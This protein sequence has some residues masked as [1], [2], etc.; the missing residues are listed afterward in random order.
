MYFDDNLDK[1]IASLNKF[2]FAS[3]DILIMNNATI[4]GSFALYLQ[5]YEPCEDDDFD[6]DIVVDS[7]KDFVN[8]DFGHKKAK[9]L[10]SKHSI[11]YDVDGINIHISEKICGDAIQFYTC[12]QLA[13]PIVLSCYIKE[14]YNTTYRN[15]RDLLRCL[16]KIERENLCM[17]LYN[18]NNNIYH[19]QSKIIHVLY[20]VLM[21]HNGEAVNCAAKELI[22]IEVEHEM[23]KFF[24]DLSSRFEYIECSYDFYDSDV[25]ITVNFVDKYTNTG[26]N[27]ETSTKGDS[28]NIL[29]LPSCFRLN[30]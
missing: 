20:K 26:Y 11:L 4:S 19:L 23:I 2:A 8:L 12:P 21:N 15:S 30:D 5:F 18:V 9:S 14:A 27:I 22:K 25:D 1:I 3:K 28:L 7:I 10:F 16:T 29:N 24:L 17:K 13:L 6:I